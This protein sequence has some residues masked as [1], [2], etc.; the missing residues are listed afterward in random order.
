MVIA[1]GRGGSASSISLSVDLNVIL[2][3]DAEI[4]QNLAG[5]PGQGK[6]GFGTLLAPVTLELA[7]R[8]SISQTTLQ[9][10][11]TNLIHVCMTMFCL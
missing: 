11:Q 6:D 7:I 8:L 10:P 1:Y 3:I 5:A 9:P 2:M 4:L